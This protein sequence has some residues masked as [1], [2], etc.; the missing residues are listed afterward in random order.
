MVME[1]VWPVS[2]RNISPETTIYI[3]T[4]LSFDADA[5]MLLSGEKKTA[6]T[7]FQW[8]FRVRSSAPM[9]AFHRLILQS[10]DADASNL[11]S[12]RMLQC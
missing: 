4:I 10:P 9:L 7:E 3:L 5:N 6:L 1:C 12:V 8:P 11:R 2:V